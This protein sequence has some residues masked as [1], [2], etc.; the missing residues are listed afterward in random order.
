LAEVIACDIYQVLQQNVNVNLKTYRELILEKGSSRDA[1][2]MINDLLG[3][4]Y[5][6]KAFGDW[7]HS[8]TQQYEKGTAATK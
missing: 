8:T 4:P 3:R 1:N 2:D 6:L 5:G 7:L